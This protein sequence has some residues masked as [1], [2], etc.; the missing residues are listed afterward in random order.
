MMCVIL[1]SFQSFLAGLAASGIITSALRLVTK[2]AFE[3]TKDGLRVGASE[4]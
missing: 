3:N 4:S 2:A 1:L